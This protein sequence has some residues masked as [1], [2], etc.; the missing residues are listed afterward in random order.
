MASR[1][2]SR[3]EFWPE[4]PDARE[5]V[6]AS[7]RAAGGL[8]H[9]DEPNEGLGFDPGP[10]PGFYAVARYD[11]VRDVCRDDA[12]FRSAPTSFTIGDPPLGSNAGNMI[13]TDNPEHARLRRIVQSA[14]HARRVAQLEVLF[15]DEARRLVGAAAG[16]GECDFV[17]TIAAELPLNTTCTMMGV[18]PSE[19]STV[20]RASHTIITMGSDPEYGMGGA[21]GEAVLNAALAV[22]GVMYELYPERIASPLDDVTSS[23]VH[24][25]ADGEALT[26]DELATFFLLL[27]VGGIETTIAALSNGLWAL[28][29]H[30][31]QRRRW[32]SDPEGLALSGANE[33]V[34]WTTPLVWSR[35]TVA[36]ATTLAGTD[37]VEGDKLM[38][39]YASANRDG[40][41]FE[42]PTAFDVART[43]NHHF[44]Y[45]A[46][47]E[48]YC[49]GAHLSRREIMALFREL[50]SL[51]GDFRATAPPDRVR[52]NIY[53]GVRSIR[54]QIG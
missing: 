22:A 50:T 49:L 12:T 11:D 24:A 26:A 8:P 37:L 54:C 17:E 14:Y 48:H 46:P 28:T 2:L 34:R 25:N 30:E 19:R 42:S 32:Q 27:I 53:D 39:L 33:I 1:D 20:L 4:D 40:T 6:F 41:G 44:G 9:F 18:P 3:F 29:K 38:V 51:R 52:S 47:G 23:L 21:R 10:R 45:G 35:R 5:S 31:E 36:G 15:E 16:S 7:L 13:S 43:P